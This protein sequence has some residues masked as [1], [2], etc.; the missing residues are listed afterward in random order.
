MCLTALLHYSPVK[1]IKV[2]LQRTRVP[3]A[4]TRILSNAVITY[5]S[6]TYYTGELQSENWNTHETEQTTALK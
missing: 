4:G 2:Q 3:N 6:Y 1:F 5:F